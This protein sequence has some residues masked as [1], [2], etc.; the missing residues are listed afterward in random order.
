[1]LGA[2]LAR[3]DDYKS[4]EGTVARTG[5]DSDAFIGQYRFRI[6]A[7]QQL[8]ISAQM[9]KDEDV[10]YAG[11]TKPHASPLVGSTTIHSPEQERRLLEIGYNRQGTGE[12]PVNLDVRVYRQEMERNINSWANNLNRDIVT[13]RV[14]FETNGF[15][16]KADWLVHPQHLL[17]FGVN[18]WQMTGNPDRKMASAAPSPR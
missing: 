18:A 8:R 12:A 1:M 17:S 2:S 16:A 10:W 6:D 3:I 11:S 13:N 7:Q 15:D 5:Y 4:P 14:T 9:H